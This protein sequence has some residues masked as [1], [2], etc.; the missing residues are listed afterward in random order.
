MSQ[1]APSP[2]TST[3]PSVSSLLSQSRQNNKGT[4]SVLNPDE[5][6][7]MLDQEHIVR[8]TEEAFRKLADYTRAE[9]LEVGMLKLYEIP[10]TT[11]DCQLLTAMNETTKEKYSQM[12]IMSQR[13]MKEMSK[14]Q[15]TC[16]CTRI[17]DA[18]FSSFMTQIDDISQQAAQMEKTAKA[19]DDYSRYLEEKLIKTNK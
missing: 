2:S 10:V 15:N 5:A 17:L 11:E 14:L 3:S 19:L 1:H 18:D 9:L 13:L 7:K 16:K 4:S 6:T 8:Q 12:S